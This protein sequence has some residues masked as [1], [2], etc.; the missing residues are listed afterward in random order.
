MTEVSDAQDLATLLRALPV[1]DTQLPE[2]DFAQSPADPGELFR[3][4]LR[5]AVDAG[6]PEPHAMTLST[7]DAAGMPDARVLILKNLDAHGWWFASSRTSSKG[8]QL[9]SCVG[10]ALTFHWKILGR[11]VRVRGVVT[12]A[13]ATASAADFR[14][15]AL[16]AR[17][18]A[19]ASRESQPLGS[20]SELTD[21]VA[22]AARTLADDPSVTPSRWTLY[23]LRPSEIEFWQAD[24]ARQHHRLRYRHTDAGWVNGQ[25]WP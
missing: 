4:W 13:S 14:A 8:Q 1:F 22:E 5:E 6:E 25:L 12:A 24:R 16:G 18:V 17:A 2:V 19:L 21:A 9:D 20:R 3:R 15:R 10:A 11:Q 23:V 7:V